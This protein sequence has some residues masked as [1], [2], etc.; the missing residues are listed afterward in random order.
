MKIMNRHSRLVN[1]VNINHNKCI[2]ILIL[3]HF[4]LLLTI[5]SEGKASKVIKEIKETT[6]N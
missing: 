6:I 5:R 1:C 2:S 3:L 4:P